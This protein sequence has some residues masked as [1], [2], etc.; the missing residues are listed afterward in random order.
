MKQEV[1]KLAEEEIKE[2]Y[3]NHATCSNALEYAFESYLID[4]KSARD[5]QIRIEFKKAKKKEPQRS[6][7][8]IIQDLEVKFDV[9]S[10]TVF[11]AVEHIK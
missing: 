4:G 1:I 8:K 3:G 11:R 7:N 10:W 5:Y 2:I 9:S 6:N